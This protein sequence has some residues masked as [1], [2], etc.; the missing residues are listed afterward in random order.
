MNVGRVISSAFLDS[1][2]CYTSVRYTMELFPVVATWRGI[3]R[4][5]NLKNLRW[6]LN[7]IIIY[8]KACKN[9]VL[10]MNSKRYL[11]GLEVVL[12]S[13]WCKNGSCVCC[14]AESITVPCHTFLRRQ[15]CYQ[16]IPCYR[17]GC[18]NRGPLECMPDCGVLI[19]AQRRVGLNK[20]CKLSVS[21]VIVTASQPIRFPIHP[22][23]TDKTNAHW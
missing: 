13:L 22:K 8:E 1:K 3:W 12:E 20:Y 16:D 5:T 4:T 14:L 11:W 18:M 10:M 9:Q 7:E 19:S 6:W 23:Q 2:G 21:D 15:T 17:P